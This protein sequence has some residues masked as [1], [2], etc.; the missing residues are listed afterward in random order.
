MI[1][2]VQKWGNSQ[3]VRIPKS[4]FNELN[5]TNGQEL[6]MSVVDGA[7]LI[8]IL[9]PKRKSIEQLFKDY[10]GDYKCEE[11]DWGEKV[12]NEEW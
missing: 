6:D 1:T 2:N 11:V 12:G 9:E 8:K 7:I 3:G 4:I 10:D 5:I